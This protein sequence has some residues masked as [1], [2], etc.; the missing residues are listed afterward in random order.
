[1]AKKKRAGSADEPQFNEGFDSGRLLGQ[2]YTY[3]L[4]TRELVTTL[5]ASGIAD[6][7]ATPFAQLRMQLAYVSPVV[8]ARCDEL[9]AMLAKQQGGKNAG[10]KVVAQGVVAGGDSS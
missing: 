5:Q 10:G 6:G 7:T 9:A 1:M 2:L 8:M 3:L 4:S